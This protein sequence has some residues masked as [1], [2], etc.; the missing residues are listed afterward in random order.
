MSLTLSSRAF[1]QQG[2]IPRQYTCEGDELSPPLAWSGAPEGT[3]S[4]ALVLDDPDAPD[5]KAPRVTWVHWVLYDMPPT[6][7]TLPQDLAAAGLPV[8]V[9]EG[10]NSWKR[11]GY[12][13]PCP[14]IGR[15][16]YVFKLYALD[17]A[18]PKLERPTKA[19]L[20]K[21]MDGHILARAKL[22]A[23]YQKGDR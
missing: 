18:L 3:R 17:T 23:T 6:L 14:P 11:T 15:H 19:A 7:G 8:G 13:A 1:T 21:A 20:E 2:E 10:L 4:F 5:P 16:R 12:G 22:V 9:R